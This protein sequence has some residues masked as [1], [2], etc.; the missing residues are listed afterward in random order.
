MSDTMQIDRPRQVGEKVNQFGDKLRQDLASLCRR[1]WPRG[2]RS[3]SDG[4]ADWGIEIGPDRCLAIRNGTARIG[5]SEYLAIRAAAKNEA[6]LLT[7]AI[8]KTRIDG[9]DL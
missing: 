5:L 6:A 9:L 1:V 7:A 3:M 8:T 4:L 2:K